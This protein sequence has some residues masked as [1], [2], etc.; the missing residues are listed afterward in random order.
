VTLGAF[1]NA[2]KA[3]AGLLGT[4]D[5]MAASYWGPRTLQ[6]IQSGKMPAVRVMHAGGS[7][8]RVTRNGDADRI[9]DTT[10]LAVA[11]F[12]GDADTAAGLAESCRQLL[13]SERG[14]TA[15]G[16]ALIDLAETMQ[17]PEL[18]TSPDSALPQCV[19]AAYIVSMRR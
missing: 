5:G 19:T 1:P 12:A 7:Q 10:Y 14:I 13:I 9:T 6:V 15:P 11:V 16:G 4:V 3:V 18:V 2:A 8:A 17:S